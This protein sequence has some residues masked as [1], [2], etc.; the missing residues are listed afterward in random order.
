MYKHDVTSRFESEDHK[1]TK[2]GKQTI[3]DQVEHSLILWSEIKPIFDEAFE[4]EDI[5]LIIKCL[6]AWRYK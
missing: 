4:N 1:S 3:K 2:E 6:E 5:S